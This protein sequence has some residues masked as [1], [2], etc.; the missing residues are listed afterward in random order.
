MECS[1]EVHNSQNANSAKEII[2]LENCLEMFDAVKSDF[3]R[4]MK[5]LVIDARGVEPEVKVLKMKRNL[6]I[7]SFE[8]CFGPY[9]KPP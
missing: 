6:Q 7:E 9:L 5:D 3:S 8:N 4:N 1:V 2:E